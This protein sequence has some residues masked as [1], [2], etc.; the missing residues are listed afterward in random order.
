[1][2]CHEGTQSKDPEKLK[3]EEKLAEYAEKKQEI[4]WKRITW[5]ASD[6]NVYFSHRRH[7]TIAKIQ[8]AACHGPVEESTALPTRLVEVD[9]EWCTGCHERQRVATAVG[10]DCNACHR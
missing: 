5:L 3:R 9:M 4:P 2:D 10:R 7:A 8:C 6:A 1:M